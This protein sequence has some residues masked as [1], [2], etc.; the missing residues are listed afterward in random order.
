MASATY[1]RY[2][3]HY[4][5][6]GVNG[7]IEFDTRNPQEYRHLQFLDKPTTGDLNTWLQSNAVKMPL[8]GTWVFNSTLTNFP[9]GSSDY[10]ISFTCGDVTYSKIT[11]SETSTMKYGSTA[12]YGNSN[13]IGA[14]RTITFT[15]PVKYEG[16]EEFVWWFVDNA[17]PR[18]SL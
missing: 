6:S 2:S 16:N 4:Y 14:Y 11:L 3:N 17:T 5:Y 10:N 13:W 15:S 7:I 1:I 9:S 8:T 12:V 18:L